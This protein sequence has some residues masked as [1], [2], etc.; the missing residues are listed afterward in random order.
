MSEKI[1]ETAKVS[2][3]TGIK[4]MT[5]KEL[6]I[7]E[8]N[9]DEILV[10]VEGCGIC[11]TDVHEYKGDPFGYIPVQLG[12][13]GTGTIVKLGKNVTK[14]WSGKPVKVGDKIV[15]GLR[16]CGKC[17]ICLKEPE[18][19]HLCENGEIFGLMPGEDHYFN[20]WFGEY[21]KVNAGGVIF[22]VS[23]MDL[24]SRLLIEP[25]SV[26]VHAVE[27]AKQIFDFKHNSYVLIQGCGPIGLLLLT[28]VRTM[29]VRN[30]IAVDSDEKRL[31]LAKE[32]GA[33]ECIN[34]MKEKDPV[35]AVKAVTQGRGAEMAFQCTGSPKAASMIWKYVRRGGSMCELGFFVNNGDATYNPH[36]DICNKEIKVTGSWTY[37][38]KDWVHATEFLKEAKDR[39]LPVQKLITHRYGIEDMNDAME[40]NISMQGCKIAYIN[41]NY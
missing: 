33:K 26:V 29:G 8:I 38:S 9:D 5:V 39:G 34:F 7:P 11:G 36:L 1:P 14:D 22:N 41:Q 21:M 40:M 18:K 12:H 25:S 24:D 2:V 19:I 27:N 15:T 10:H 32:L 31:A 20:A 13:E 28:L 3:L 4:E 37:Q 6:P 16:P 23:D 35:E 17:E 30:I